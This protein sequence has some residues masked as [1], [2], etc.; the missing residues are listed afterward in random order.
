MC[1]I[2]SHLTDNAT[3]NKHRKAP[4]EASTA[5]WQRK[6]NA[7]C[8]QDTRS[9]KSKAYLKYAFR[10]L[11]CLLATLYFG[12]ANTG[13]FSFRP[14]ASSLRLS[15][16]GKSEFVLEMELNLLP[17]TPVFLGLLDASA[18]APVKEVLVWLVTTTL[19]F[20]V[21]FCHEHGVSK[22]EGGTSKGTAC[23]DR[24]A[25]IGVLGSA[26]FDPQFRSPCFGAPLSQS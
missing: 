13:L 7:Y 16:S 6:S 23:F 9:R 14:P 3:L 12:G 21:G 26:C 17:P 2:S 10:S 11:A 1:A 20:L 18:S 22:W 4:T 24:R 15:L 19:F 8:T 5:S 25:W